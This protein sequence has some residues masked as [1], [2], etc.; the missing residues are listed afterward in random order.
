[1]LELSPAL[2]TSLFLCDHVPCASIAQWSI[3]LLWLAHLGNF[4]VIV[5][6]TGL[7]NKFLIRIYWW[8]RRN[9]PRENPWTLHDGDPKGLMLEVAFI[10][11]DDCLASLSTYGTKVQLE[12]DTDIFDSS[13]TVGN[14]AVSIH[15]KDCKLNLTT[16]LLTHCPSTYPRS[17]VWKSIYTFD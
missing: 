12:L 11:A 1:M 2:G 13:T 4:H 17:F 15:H 14:T 16:T 8:I 10:S 5:S 6:R 9:S 3:C 7:W